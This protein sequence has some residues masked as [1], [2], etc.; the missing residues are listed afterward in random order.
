MVLKGITASNGSS[1]RGLSL[2]NASEGLHY[3]LCPLSIKQLLC[4]HCSPLLLL[5][6]LGKSIFT[7]EKDMS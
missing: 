7:L 4:F 3:F 1:I 2:N 6:E 5:V